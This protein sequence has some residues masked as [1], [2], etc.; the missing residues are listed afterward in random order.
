MVSER[1]WSILFALK[2]MIGIVTII[3]TYLIS[4]DLNEWICK[5][6]KQWWNLLDGLY[7][8]LNNNYL[9]TLLISLSLIM[10]MFVYLWRYLKDRYFS[11]SFISFSI[12]LCILMLKQNSW[13]YAYTFI[14]SVPYNWLISG[15]FA[16]LIIWSFQ[17]LLVIKSKRPKPKRKEVFFLVDN[18]DASIQNECRDMYAQSLVDELLLTES[19]GLGEEAFAVAIIGG[20]GTGKTVFLNKMKEKL[21]PKAIVVDFKPW[22][23]QNDR[24]LVKDFFDTLAQQLSPYYSEIETPLKKYVNMLYSMRMHINSDLILQHLPQYQPEDLESRKAHIEEALACIGKPIVVTIDDLDRLE[25]KEIFEVLRIIRNTAQFKNVIYIVT[26][27]KEYIISQLESEIHVSADYLEKIF[28]L[29]LSMPKVDERALEESFRNCC[30]S[31]IDRITLVNQALN[32]LTEDDYHFIIKSLYSYR[33]IKRFARQFTF[34]A[35]FMV[36]SF[37]DSTLV[38]YFDVMVLNIIQMMDDRLYDTMWKHPEVLF[39]E[40]KMKTNGCVFYQLRD[41]VSKKDWN[42]ATIYFMD[43]LFKKEPKKADN[44]IQMKDSYYKYFNMNQPGKELTAVEFKAMLKKPINDSNNGMRACVRGW[45][46]S[47]ESKSCHSIYKQFNDALPT[48]NRKERVEADAKALIAATCYW[49]EYEFRTSDG[50]KGILCKL[51][52]QAIYDPAILTSIKRYA[53][54]MLER[55]IQINQFEKMALIYTSIYGFVEKGNKLLFDKNEIQQMISEEFEHLANYQEWDAILLIRDDGNMLRVSVDNC[56][57]RDDKNGKQ[58]NLMIDSAIA[59]FSRPEYRSNNIREAD[60]LR[61]SIPSYTIHGEL[62]NPEYDWVHLKTTFGEDL[63]KLEE[64]I[65]KCFNWQ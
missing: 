20:W 8:L 13:R 28:Q 11:L 23:S 56:K 27:D 40:K 65:E 48:K 7:N 18:T 29:E 53:K 24:H 31:M 3:L 32:Q 6:T 57:M 38:S 41:N 58:C 39:D 59:F 47:K 44:G 25:A 52:M 10:C 51:L 60:T 45:V 19:C 55:L 2:V 9:L 50:V 1:R 4:E 63:T 54:E 34:N 64:Y 14:P 5:S 46:L 30:R 42:A 21:K 26:Y 37:A 22:N 61:N 43:R 36:K 17:K 15:I 49:M 16:I 62:S 35:N 33:K 12:I